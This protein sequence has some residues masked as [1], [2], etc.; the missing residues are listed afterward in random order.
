MIAIAGPRLPRSG[1]GACCSGLRRV[2]GGSIPRRRGIEA[3]VLT[4]P[5][6]L[7]VLKRGVY[8]GLA[9]Q[10]GLT[11]GLDRAGVSRRVVPVQANMTMAAMITSIAG[12]QGKRRPTKPPSVHA[13]A[14]DRRAEAASG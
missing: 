7:D 14:A 1:G 12:D 6:I 5:S 10:R 11:R 2:N 4:P 9:R 13:K 8:A 3:D